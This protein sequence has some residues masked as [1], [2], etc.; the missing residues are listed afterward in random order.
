MSRFAKSIADLARNLFKIERPERKQQPVYFSH[1]TDGVIDYYTE[2]EPTVGEWLRSL[3][4]SAAGVLA[5]IRSIFVCTQWLPRYNLTWL[6]G[7]VI[8]GLTVGFVVIPQAMAYA[9]LAMLS[10][11]YGLYTSFVGAALYWIFGT[12]KDIVI[13]TTAVGSLLIGS[14]ISSVQEQRPGVYT[15]EEIAKA[16]TSVSGMILLG[17]G[18][19]R[20]GWIIEFIP[21]IPI[22]AFVTAAAITIMATQFPT[23]M[24]ITGVNTRDAPY[25]VIINSLKGLPRTQVDAAIG[26]SSIALLYAIRY[27]CARMEHR[28]SAKQKMWAII[29]SLRL[30]FTILLYTLVS[31]LVNRNNTGKSPF[32]I[33]GPIERGFKHAG[34]PPLD[35]DLV[36]LVLPELPAILIILIIE[37]IAIAKSFGHRFNYT[38]VPSQEILA[39]G[40]SNLLGTFVGGY[41]CT[42]S[43]GASAVLSKAGVRT[44]LA[45]LVSAVVLVLALYALTAVFYYIPM[46]AL[47]GLIIHAIANLPTTPRTLYT[48]W[49]LSPPE[50]IV[51]WIGVLVAIFASLE[52]SIYVTICV[53]LALLLI[54]LARAQGRFLG[55]TRVYHYPY[56]DHPEPHAESYKHTHAEHGARN[57]Y[58]PLDHHDASNPSVTIS[59]PHP[60]VFIYRF[61]SGFNYTNQAQHIRLLVNHIRTH[62]RAGMARLADNAHR[63]WSESAPLTLVDAEEEHLPRLRAVVLDC[64]AVDNVDIT[65]VQGLVDARKALDRHACAGAGGAGDGECVQWHFAGLCNRWARR[66]FAVA[67]FGTPVQVH[68]PREGNLEVPRGEIEENPL[69][70][71]EP[72]YVVASPTVPTSIGSSSGGGK[73]QMVHGADRPFF[74]VD[75]MEAVDAAV[76]AAERAEGRF[77]GRHGH[78]TVQV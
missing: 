57:I 6:V 25:L 36:T 39:Q 13:G 19:L 9:L 74:H 34:P 14:A 42:G 43:F 51:W 17:I 31:W 28:Y 4:P 78:V 54:R 49:K 2:P 11:E 16:L 55:Q 71:W 63:T 22:S 46:A 58:L 61:P 75:L 65:S 18:F 12:S 33:V 24:G 50:F 48:Y 21:Y 73:E 29:S 76:R 8:A 69:A 30:T 32:R 53:S 70:G 56:R 27:F 5:Y 1:G 64:T 35:A 59:A 41:V 67:G 60:G 47:A 72:V 3:A 7:D 23:L 66:A 38:V 40:A 68:V 45:G 62:T 37:H 44:P 26:L 15:N 77:G 10:P 52:I 20:L